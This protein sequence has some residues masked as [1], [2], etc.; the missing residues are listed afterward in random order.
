MTHFPFVQRSDEVGAGERGKEGGREGGGEGRGENGRGEGE[1]WGV[2]C[3]LHFSVG[4]SPA[5]CPIPSQP[6]GAPPPTRS[7]PP[8]GVGFGCLGFRTR[9]TDDGIINNSIKNAN[10]KRFHL[11]FS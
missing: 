3:S 11:D 10:I 9:L 7:G 5:P 6:A 4:N 8:A 1:G 2:G